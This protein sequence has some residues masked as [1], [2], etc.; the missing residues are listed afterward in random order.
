V[1]LL[2]ADEPELYEPTPPPRPKPKPKPRPKPRPSVE[3]APARQAQE[4]EASPEEE[5]EP[6]E[7]PPT[8]ETSPIRESPPPAPAAPSAAPSPLFP[9]LQTLIDRR[10]SGELPT[11]RAP[12][13]PVHPNFVG[14][15][16]WTC[17]GGRESGEA[18]VHTQSPDGAI[19]GDWSIRSTVRVR[20]KMEGAI[21]G[22]RVE[23]RCRWKVFIIKGRLTAVAPL[24]PAGVEPMRID[25]TWTGTNPKGYPGDFSAVKEGP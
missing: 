6:T 18:R 7:A 17:C 4:V 20:G 21:K 2:V 3:E 24:P 25:G 19:T 11:V 12:P 13:R 22:D 23:F 8:E 16:R 5:T 1:T 15:W 9:R 10:R 14:T